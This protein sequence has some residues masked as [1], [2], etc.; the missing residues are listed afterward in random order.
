MKG[1]ISV[2][3]KIMNHWLWEEK[4]FDKRSAWVDLLL[5]ANHQDNKFLLGNELVEVKTGSFITS[6][7]KLMNRW[8]WGNTKVRNFLKLL[9]EDGMINY[10]G[11]NYTVIE[12]LNYKNYQKQ[13]D[14]SYEIS[15][16]TEEQQTDSK[17]LANRQQIAS[18]LTANTNN[19]DNND[20]N[21]LLSLYSEKNTE[22][23]N[24][25][26]TCPQ[27]CPQDTFPNFYKWVDEK[28]YAAEAKYP[29]EEPYYLKYLHEKANFISKTKG[30]EHPE[31]IRAIKAFEDRKV[32]ASEEDKE[33][34]QGIS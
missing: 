19:N 10:H 28:G 27:G 23:Q 31:T 7:S 12:I 4:P 13:T 26:Q 3:R 25:P 14:I 5:L 1:W 29:N 24:C 2:H 18:K 9:K 20:N 30:K 17:L 22:T 15:N 16:N 21:M 8:G 33:K 32:I 11:K 6:Q 34:A